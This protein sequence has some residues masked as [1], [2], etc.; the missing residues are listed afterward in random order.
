MCLSIRFPERLARFKEENGLSWRTIA[1]LLGV[2]L[3]RLRQWRSK[4][5]TP[6]PAHFFLLLTIAD[7]MGLRAGI[8]MCPDR[9][10]PE[11]YDRE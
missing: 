6:S 2:S 1:R 7:E 8:L 3:H 5:V 4:G 10:L 9:D 11:E